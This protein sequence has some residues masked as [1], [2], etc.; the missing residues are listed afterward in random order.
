MITVFPSVSVLVQTPYLTYTSF[1]E[2][3]NKK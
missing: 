1:I 3:F 2:L